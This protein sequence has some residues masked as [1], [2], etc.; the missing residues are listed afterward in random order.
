MFQVRERLIGLR[1]ALLAFAA[2][3]VVAAGFTS[4]GASALL[5]P[6][7]TCSPAFV[8]A[9]IGGEVKCLHAG[10]FC[11]ARYERQ[12]EGYGFVCLSGR[13]TARTAPPRSTKP[14]PP[15]RHPRLLSHRQVAQN[16]EVRAV[17]TW[18]QSREKYTPTVSRMRLTIHRGAASILSS[19]IVSP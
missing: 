5:T 4:D 18:L 16:G 13:L 3:A 7:K 12:Y 11:A 17:Q 10:E 6:G 8:R 2:A 9:I 14:P 19:R 1:L 15:P